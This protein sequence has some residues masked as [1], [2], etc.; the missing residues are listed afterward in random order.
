VTFAVP[1]PAL[2][3]PEAE[4]AVDAVLDSDDFDD[5]ELEDLLPEQPVRLA[6]MIATPPMAAT[7]PRFTDL[8]PLSRD[9]RRG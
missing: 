4:A 8:S 9:P 2:V 7:I 3:E 1:A 6:A 5:S